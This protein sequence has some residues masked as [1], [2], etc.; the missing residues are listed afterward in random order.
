M[1]SIRT[2][3]S[4]QETAG[5]IKTPCVPMTSSSDGAIDPSITSLRVRD[6][7]SIPASVQPA[8]W[9][10][11]RHGIVLDRNKLD[12]DNSCYGPPLENADTVPPSNPPPSATTNTVRS[13]HGQR[14]SVLPTGPSYDCTLVVHIPMP[15][16][17]NRVLR[18]GLR[19]S[20][21]DPIRPPDTL[22]TPPT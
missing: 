19:V 12:H 21:A 15:S 17:Q 9:K 3:P 18:D 16:V 14:W 20:S 7:F 13:R 11:S 4:S 10:E 2:R 6:L 1:F 22:P 8:R 5:L